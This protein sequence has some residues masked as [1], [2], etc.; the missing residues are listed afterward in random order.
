GIKLPFIIRQPGKKSAFKVH[1][2][3]H[4]LP[5]EEAKFKNPGAAF[6]TLS[7]FKVRSSGQ[8]AAERDVLY[9]SLEQE[10]DQIELRAELDGRH[11]SYTLPQGAEM[12]RRLRKLY[13][14]LSSGESTKAE[15]NPL[16][17]ESGATLFTPIA[18][19]LDAATEIRFIIQGKFLIFPLDLLH[20]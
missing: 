6:A 11:Q 2:I 12:A 16:L 9:L 18:A 3:K 17:K 7:T 20:F 14:L 10:G 5:I 19:M 4:N 15:L 8:A 1:E 13:V